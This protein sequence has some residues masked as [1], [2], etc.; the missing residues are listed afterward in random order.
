MLPSRNTEK[1]A[2][3]PNTLNGIEFG[4][5]DV[6]SRIALTPSLVDRSWDQVVLASL[7]SA[8]VGWKTCQKINETVQHG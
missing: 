2:I 5:F 8:M 6:D 7:N 4:C 1:Q 3:V